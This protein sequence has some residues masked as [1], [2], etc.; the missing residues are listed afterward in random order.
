MLRLRL[1]R[2]SEISA[3]HSVDAAA[4]IHRIKDADPAR[5]RGD[6]WDTGWAAAYPPI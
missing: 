2:G 5:V 6:Y 3:L 1:W 4:P